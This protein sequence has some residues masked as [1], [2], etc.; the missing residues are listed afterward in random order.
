MADI[1]DKTTGV[2]SLA[3]LS[4]Y[5]GKTEEENMKWIAQFLAMKAEIYNRPQ[6]MHITCKINE[7]ESERRKNEY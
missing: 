1:V 3:A 6:T 5:N 4:K 7:V 2:I